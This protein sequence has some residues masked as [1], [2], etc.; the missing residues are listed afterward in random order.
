MFVQPTQQKEGS[1][2][3]AA[4][5]II[6]WVMVGFGL[7]F[8]G[9]FFVWCVA[10]D[11]NLQGDVE[12]RYLARVKDDANL[13][14]W[15]VRVFAVKN[16]L[17]LVFLFLSLVFF[18]CTILLA[19]HLWILPTLY[20]ILATVAAVGVFRFIDTALLWVIKNRAEYYQSLKT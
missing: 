7:L 3:A 5:E 18:A 4:L 11:T 10:E 2:F 14:M 12:A 17:K 16:F 9:H 8:A 19:L 6:G 1:M 15:L 20:V 13:E